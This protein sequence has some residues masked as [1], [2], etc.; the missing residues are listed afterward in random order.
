MRL[1]PLISRLIL[2]LGGLFL[3][4]FGFTARNATLMVLLPMFGVYFMAKG[5]FFLGAALES[6]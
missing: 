5:A 1:L 3:V 4:T 2:L 6:N